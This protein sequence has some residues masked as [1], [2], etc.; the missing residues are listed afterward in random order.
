MKVILRIFAYTAI[1]RLYLLGANSGSVW[2]ELGWFTA[3]AIV[4]YTSLGLL[5]YEKE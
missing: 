1:C 2:G 4:F 3:S 5:H